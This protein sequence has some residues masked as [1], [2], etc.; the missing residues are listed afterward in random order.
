MISLRKW[1]VVDVVTDAVT[2]DTGRLG[3][4]ARRWRI[5][6]RRDMHG[7]R[8]AMAAHGTEDVQPPTGEVFD[9]RR[10]ADQSDYITARSEVDQERRVDV[11]DEQRR[12]AE[13]E[14]ATAV[15]ESVVVVPAGEEKGG[16]DRV[17]DG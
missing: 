3:K 17:A 16:N 1:A 6:D 9:G 13:V 8:I 11:E 7:R 10:D 4:E 12:M 2:G 15:D 14:P 5:Q